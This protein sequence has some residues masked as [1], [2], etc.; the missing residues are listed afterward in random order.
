MNG[1]ERRKQQKL[2]QI[3]SAAFQL[4]F[5][6]G[7][8]KVSV[9]EIADKAKV[10]PATI[11]NYFK[12]KE[13]LYSDML[14]DWMNK[15]LEQYERILGSENP[16]PEKT[17]EIMLC[18]AKNLKLLSN[19]SH[20]A[21]FSGQVEFVRLMEEYNERKVMPFFKRFV[22]MG[23]QEGYVH[24]DISEEMMMLYFTMFKNELGRHWETSNQ[25]GG[26]ILSVEQLVEFF[27]YGLS[28]QG[29]TP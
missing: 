5:S 29:R 17:K 12:T 27:F 10:S 11:Y 24:S 22:A 20:Q 21:A 14:M 23:K 19:E 9:N 4:F 3:Y 2:E 16:F 6:F 25:A 1:F 18:E 7:F 15:Q 26:S 28:R 8:Q 13:Q